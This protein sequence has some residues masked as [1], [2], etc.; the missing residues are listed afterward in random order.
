MK[1]TTVNTTEFS[2]H[3]QYAITIL[4]E[5]DDGEFQGR[6]GVVSYQVLQLSW[7]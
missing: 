2:L 6:I 4:W 5:K 3:E 7:I 1:N